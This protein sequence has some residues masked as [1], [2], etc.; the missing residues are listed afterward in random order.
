M[1][2][3]AGN[4][5]SMPLKT[6][7]GMSVRPTQD[8]IKETLFNMIQNYVPGS[9]FLD[10]YAGSGQIGIEALSRGAGHAYFSDVDR[11]ALGCIKDNLAFTKLSDRATVFKGDAA[12]SL[13]GIHEKHFDIIYLDPP[14]STGVE[15]SVLRALSSMPQADS[16]SVIIIENEKD[17]PLD[18]YE[19]LGYSIERV[20]KY[21]R[22]EHIFLRKKP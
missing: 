13:N 16:E 22:S 20:K 10:L 19:N 5:R 14:Y 18:S 12:V 9:V 1:R 3:I 7:R 4:A 8:R 2:V 21:L 11:D 6:P 15:E 17:M